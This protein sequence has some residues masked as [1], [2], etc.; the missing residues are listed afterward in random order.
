M[1]AGG[2]DTAQLIEWLRTS[3]SDLDPCLDAADTIER[4]QRERDALKEAVPFAIGAIEDAIYCEDGLDGDDGQRMIHILR[5]AVELGTF[6]RSEYG[7]LPRPHA[8][9][10]LDAVRDKLGMD[11]DDESCPVEAIERLQ[12]ECDKARADLLER[13]ADAQRAIHEAGE[14]REKLHRMKGNAGSTLA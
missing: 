13:T 12:R 9:V 5:E 4:L 2:I 7:S 14:L 8:D 6:G 1:S 10:T 11:A 3:G